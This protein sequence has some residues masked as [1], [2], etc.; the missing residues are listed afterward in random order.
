VGPAHVGKL[1]KG[2]WFLWI[3]LE[4]SGF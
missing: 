3:S 2:F 1:G 4:F